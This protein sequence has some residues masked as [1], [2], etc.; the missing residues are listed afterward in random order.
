MASDD[1]TALGI[2]ASLAA[3]IVASGEFSEGGY[4]VCR[5]DKKAQKVSAEQIVKWLSSK[6]TPPCLL[7]GKKTELLTGK[8]LDRNPL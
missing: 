4:R 3:K 1:M 7:C 2:S 5:K 6:G 8:D